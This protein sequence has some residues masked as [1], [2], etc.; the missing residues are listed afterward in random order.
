VSVREIQQELEYKLL[1]NNYQAESLD[2]FSPKLGFGVEGK[3]INC[4]GVKIACLFCN[5]HDKTEKIDLKMNFLFCDTFP[6]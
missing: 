6:F 3:R 2:K 5:F 4:F 1:Q